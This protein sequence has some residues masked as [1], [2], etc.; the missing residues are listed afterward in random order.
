MTM[1]DL[2]EFIRKISIILINYT[3]PSQSQALSHQ[4]KVTCT[5]VTIT[6]G[7]SPK[8][9]RLMSIPKTTE[10]IMFTESFDFVDNQVSSDQ[11]FDLSPFSFYLTTT[12][13]GSNDNVTKITRKM[14]TYIS[15]YQVSIC[16]S[17]IE[18]KYI[19]TA[20]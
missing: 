1:E 11:T 20:S 14:N 19:R 16:Y 7:F 6:L 9:T 4:P 10:S 18:K 12:Y 3:E 15:M 8:M 17:L 2:R 13:Y 5:L